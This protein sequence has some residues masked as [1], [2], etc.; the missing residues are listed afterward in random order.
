MGTNVVRKQGLRTQ[1]DGALIFTSQMAESTVE[2]LI[3]KR[4]KGQ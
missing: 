2:S 3:N 4:C 1:L